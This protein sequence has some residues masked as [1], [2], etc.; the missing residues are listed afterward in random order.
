VFD[1]LIDVALQFLDLFKFWEVLDEYE[2]GVVL[3]LG[4]PRSVWWNGRREPVVGPGLH[5]IW[6]MGVEKVLTDQMSLNSFVSREQTL[7]TAEAEQVT[8]LWACTWRIRDIKKLLL[9]VNNGEKTMFD[10]VGCVV[11]DFVREST[12]TAMCT[13]GW[14]D[15]LHKLARAQAF[16]MGIEIVSL[17]LVE[18]VRIAIAARVYHG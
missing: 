3:T 15:E 17:R 6:P 9:E 4:R 13:T 10:A 2:G 8:V 11:A 7:T 14:H 1:R 12:W 18:Q 16:K 5:W